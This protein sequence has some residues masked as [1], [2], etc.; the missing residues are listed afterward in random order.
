M[1]CLETQLNKMKTWLSSDTDMVYN[2]GQT[3]H[4]T[5]ETGFLTK[6]KDKE[7]FGTLRVMF[8]EVNSKMIWPTGTE[9]TLISTDPNIKVSLETMY[10]KDME[11][12]NGLMEL[13]TLEATKME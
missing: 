3:E 9:N 6:L 7:H 11:K 13:S 2:T 8:T 10:K 1:A 5:K 4:I 12:K